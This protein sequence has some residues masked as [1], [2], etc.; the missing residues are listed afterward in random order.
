M[1]VLLCL[2]WALRLPASEYVRRPLKTVTKKLDNSMIL[3]SLPDDFV[4]HGQFCHFAS[5]CAG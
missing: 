4:C 3:A 2:D 5:S 1:K